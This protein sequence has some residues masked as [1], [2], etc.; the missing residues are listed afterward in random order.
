MKSQYFV[1]NWVGMGTELLRREVE[2]SIKDKIHV[3]KVNRRDIVGEEVKG[4]FV[5]F[6]S[7]RISMRVYIKS[8]CNGRSA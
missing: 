7:G 4:F 1:A 3:S 2:V 5:Q 6:L 8:Y